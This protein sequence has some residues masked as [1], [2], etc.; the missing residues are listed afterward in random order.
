MTLILNLWWIV[1]EEI[2]PFN[3]LDQTV[4]YLGFHKREGKFSLV[5]SA[6]TKGQTMFSYFFL[7]R[8]THFAREGH[9][10]MPPPRYATELKC[11][12]LLCSCLFLS[13]QI[14]TEYHTIQVNTTKMEFERGFSDLRL[15]LTGSWCVPQ[16][17]QLWTNWSHTLLVKYTKSNV[18]PQLFNI[19]FIW[20]DQH[21]WVSVVRANDPWILLTF[22]QNT[23][24]LGHNTN[25][26]EIGYC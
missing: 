12:V 26:V 17:A 23:I 9:R 25:I 3:V 15:K 19:S 6:Y 1:Y 16:V 7:W 8:K 2:I 11:R 14:I 21:Q 18:C 5:T 22:R 4:A 13:I 20:E 24:I 10:P